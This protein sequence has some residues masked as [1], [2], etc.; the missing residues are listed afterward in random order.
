MRI[1]LVENELRVEYKFYQDDLIQETPI[2]FPRDEWVK[3]TWE[4]GLSQRKKGHVKVWQNDQLII[5]RSKI[6]TLPTDI[7]YSQQGTK[8]MYS[9]C[10]IGITANSSTA[11]TTLWIDD[12]SALVID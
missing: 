9:S 4:L 7:L 2:T 1:A 5:D 3:I 6:K 10:E 11:S 12:F 8:G